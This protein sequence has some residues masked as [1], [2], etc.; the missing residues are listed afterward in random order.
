MSPPDDAILARVSATG[1]RAIGF[2]GV[3][4]EERASGQPFVVD[5]TVL[6]DIAVAARSD[7]IAD[8][9]DYSRIATMVTDFIEGEPCNLI[10]TLAVR[11]LDAVTS[12]NGVRGATVTVHKPNAPVAVTF[13][14]IAV[15][16]SR[17]TV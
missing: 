5:V 7:D 11:I 6:T 9:V 3:H 16:V 10:E 13:D 12:L 1:V 15:T 17:G 14:D 4:A 2:H 8:A